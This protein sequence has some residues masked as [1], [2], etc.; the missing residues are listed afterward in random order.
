M[1]DPEPRSPS[2]GAALPQFPDVT[3]PPDPIQLELAQFRE[4]LHQLT[5]RVLV[6]PALLV[7]NIAVFVLMVI[8]G[9]GLMDPTGESLVRWGANFGPLTTRGEWWRLLTCTYIHIGVLHL[10]LNLWVLW[11]VGPLVERLTG[12]VGFAVL[13]TI[14]GIFGS[15]A[16]LYWNPEL[17]SAGASGAIFGVWG[18]LLGFLLRQRDSIPT[19]AL[20]ALR[21]SGMAFLGYN[22]VFGFFVRGID[23]AAHLGGLA[24]GFLVGLVLS[25]PL[26]AAARGRRPWRNLLAGL[27]SVPLVVLALLFVPSGAGLFLF[28][29]ERFGGVEQKVLDTYNA[30][31]K[32]RDQGAITNEEFANLIERDV[33]PEWQAVRSRIEPLQEADAKRKRILAQ[34]KEYCKLREESWTLLIE[35][36]RR[37]TPLK[38]AQQAE[39]AQQAEDAAKKL[40]ELLK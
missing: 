27:G 2:P 37:P 5:P 28:E 20:V 12:N 23:Q 21:G 30:A 22:L 11:D 32:R 31:V 6:T 1:P 38:E 29:L 24:A 8:S 17:I 15:T 3:P 19:E 7:A 36:L 16:S 10:A 26:T 9:V 35:T 34:L 13:Y 33:L 40:G 25:Q 39:R 14:A 18:A 4:T